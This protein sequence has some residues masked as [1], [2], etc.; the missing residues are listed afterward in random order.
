MTHVIKDYKLNV[1]G[2][3]K[4]KKKHKTLLMNFTAIFEWKG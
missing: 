1:F 2:F 4:L 3:N